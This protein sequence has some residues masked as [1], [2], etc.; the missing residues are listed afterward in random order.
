MAAVLVNVGIVA[1]LIVI[2]AVFVAAEISL[3]SLRESQVRNLAERG[4]RGRRV[5]K[6]VS[7]PNR[8]LG[9]VQLGVTLTAILSSAFGAVTLTDSFQRTLERAGVGHTPAYAIAFLVIALAIAFVTI[10]IGELVPKRLALQRTEGT[11][12]LFAPYL[13]RLASMARPVIFLLSVSTNMVVRLLGGDPT[14]DREQISDEELRGL[15]ASH[16]SLSVDER[17][18]IDE[19]FAASERLVR[20][21]MVPRTEVAFIDADA[22]ISA[23]LKV[24]RD[25]PHS[26]YPV[27]GE[28]QDDVIGFVHIRDLAGASARTAK[29]DT[30][31]RD[32]ARLPESKNVLAALSEMRRSGQHM[33]VV[34]D[35]YGGTAGIVT[36]EDL[37]EE[38]IGDI[39][40]EYDEGERASDA[41]RLRGGDVEVDGLL[42]LEDFTEA[43]GV[44]LPEGPY[45]TA[46]GFLIAQ[47]G[48]LPRAGEAV[49]VLQPTDEESQDPDVVVRVTVV[50]LDGRRVARLRVTVLP[51]SEGESVAAER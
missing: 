8:F 28:S 37:I 27:A 2:E 42:N 16:E 22:T 26:R 6:L 18:L 40:D 38:V 17:R 29:V 10:V 4:R 50:R 35:E 45:E 25:L 24:A 46:A 48:H 14:A 1:V 15:V 43:T 7:E 5:Q 41:R 36:L 47:L 51:V 9:T 21:V 23:T 34:V 31:T 13:D 20:E 33:A 30:I 44:V 49:E 19:V 39:R 3:V 11:A 12:K 32:V